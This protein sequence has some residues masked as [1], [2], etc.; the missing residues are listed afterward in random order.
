LRR[1]D[2]DRM[3]AY[4]GII[5]TECKAYLATQARDKGALERVAAEWREE[6]SWPGI[7]ATDALCDGC[8]TQAGWTCHHCG[9]CDIRACGTAKG[10]QT[11]AG[12]DE[13]PCERLV[14]F[15]SAV[16]GVRENVEAL[17]PG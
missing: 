15:F 3:V 17:R 11:C 16:P 1:I 7:A 10:L 8:L 13:Y 14:R 2:M 6:Y 12:C 9:E 4:C 5:C